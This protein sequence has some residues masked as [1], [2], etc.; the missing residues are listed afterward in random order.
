MRFCGSSP[1]AKP[2]NVSTTRGSG[3]LN[4]PLLSWT[5]VVGELLHEV[6]NKVQKCIDVEIIHGCHVGLDTSFFC[7]ELSS[8]FIVRITTYSR[9]NISKMSLPRLTR[10]CIILM[11]GGW[12]GLWRSGGNGRRTVK[13]GRAI[14]N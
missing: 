6:D 12:I 10:S 9:G 11:M 3:V 7:A 4:S 1:L 14:N 8:L 5:Q 2:V 13:G